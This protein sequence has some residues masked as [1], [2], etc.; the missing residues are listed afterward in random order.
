MDFLSKKAG[1]VESWKIALF[2]AILAAAIIIALLAV[3]NAVTT[4][5]VV[6]V[7]DT[8]SVTKR[9]WGGPLSTK[10]QTEVI[11]AANKSIADA[12]AADAKK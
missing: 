9:S 12:A 8:L 2:V 7:N 5:N 3:Y 6:K 11:A 10:A 1:E 4:C